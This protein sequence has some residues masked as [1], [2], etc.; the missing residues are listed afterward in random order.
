MIIERVLCVLVSHTN[1]EE[2][3][4]YVPLC[5]MSSGLES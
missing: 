1:I 5:G 3:M 2:G 4:I